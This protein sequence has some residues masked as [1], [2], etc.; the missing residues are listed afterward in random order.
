M[1]DSFHFN[2]DSIELVTREGSSEKVYI[3]NQIQS[4]NML[5]DYYQIAFFTNESESA[6]NP[7]L[8]H[9]DNS[10]TSKLI[11]SYM[12]FTGN[13]I[14]EVTIDSESESILFSNSSSKSLGSCGHDWA[15]CIN[16]MYTQLGYGSVSWWIGTAIFGSPWIAGTIIGCGYA[17]CIQN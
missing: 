13:I 6:F 2:F 11:I 12:D 9:L 16:I 5:S 3:V 8:I 10:V 14:Q 15:D 4:K 7:M 17:A 1:S